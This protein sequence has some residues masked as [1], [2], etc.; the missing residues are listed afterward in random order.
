MTTT[1]L[2]AYIICGLAAFFYVYDY[3]IQVSPA[4]MTHQLMET[5]RIG[6]VGL[7]ILGSVFFYAYAGMQIP[8][9][10]LLDRYKARNL[11]TMA[12]LIS[13]C[14][15]LL[16]SLTS[17]FNLAATARFLVGFGSAFSFVGAIYLV[18]QW[19][20]HRQFAL[21]A[22][23]IQ[24]AG[25]MGSIF[26]ELPLAHAVNYFGWR[27]TLFYIAMATF[28]LGLLFWLVIR[29]KNATKIIVQHSDNVMSAWR[30]FSIPAV[31]WIALI[32]FLCWVPVATIGALWGVPYLMKVFHW[33]NTTAAGYCSLFWLSLGIASPVIGWLSD[34]F[35]R[36]KL[37]FYFCFASGAMGSL[38]L[39]Y[40][41][42]IPLYMTII[43]LILLGLAPAIQSLTFGVAK[44]ILPKE[45]FGTA[46]G[47]INMA[48]IVG[49][50]LSQV[51]IGFILSA[52]WNHQTQNHV[53]IYS[54]HN[55]QIAMILI[56]ISLGLGLLV[57][58][59]FLPETYCQSNESEALSGPASDLVSVPDLV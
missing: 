53:P 58:H 44:D 49:G 46:T 56:P 42:A 4:V 54:L 34:R 55:Y 59:F 13:A 47:F 11:L 17:N 43:A 15:V 36:R 39:I 48:P 51:V 45:V 33:T 30:L 22:G 50:G 16:F 12:V 6:A 25:C 32:G 57:T 37:P 23:M 10:L 26:G 41:V 52:L 20:P 35:Q 29:E 9:G 19:F 27:N 8:I 7:S 2:M 1:K 18:S 40:A 5:F 24:F 28:L 38:L 21:I 31:W 3:F 14:G